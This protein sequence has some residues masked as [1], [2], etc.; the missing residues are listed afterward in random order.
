MK[1]KKLTKNNNDK[2]FKVIH[3]SIGNVCILSFPSKS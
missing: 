1:I 2:D 3:D